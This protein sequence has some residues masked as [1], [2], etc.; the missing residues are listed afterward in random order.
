MDVSPSSLDRLSIYAALAVPE[1]WRLDGDRLT[2]HVLGQD[3][4][5][6][7]ANVS[8]LFPLVKPEDLFSFLQEARNLG[9]QNVAIRRFREWVRQNQ[10][11]K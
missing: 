6:E 5:F 8:K 1:V 2:F 4:R 11:A 9:D 10:L 7:A 3:G